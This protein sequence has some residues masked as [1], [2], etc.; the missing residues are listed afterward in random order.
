MKKQIRNILTGAFV[1][2]SCFALVAMVGCVTKTTTT[3][4]PGL[5][6]ASPVTNTVTTVNTN[7]LDIDCMVLQLVG[8]P[9]L[10]YALEKEPSAR[11]IVVD[12]QIAL[13]GALNGADTNVTATITGLVGGDAALDASITPLIQGASA[14]NQQLLAKYGDKN[15]VIIGLAIL[16]SDLDIVNA[17]LA[18]VP[19]P[20][21]GN[22]VTP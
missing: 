7:N 8:T 16:R 20:V 6:G 2:V 22:P 15:A 21:T 10:I 14:L 5:N 12:I 19:A 11:P 4:T 13:Q 3:V 9:S 18:A 1:L 17:A